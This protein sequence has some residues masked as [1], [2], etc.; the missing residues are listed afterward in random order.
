MVSAQEREARLTSKESKSRVILTQ[1]L[2]QAKRPRRVV[3]S[4]G[5]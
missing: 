5:D 4:F 2:P 1:A 3:V